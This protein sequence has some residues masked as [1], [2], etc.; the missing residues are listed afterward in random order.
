LNAL[1]AASPPVVLAAHTLTSDYE[2]LRMEALH[3]TG[4]G[5]GLTL[6]LRL[7]MNSWIEALSNRTLQAPCDST[8]RRT[9]VIPS[10]QS[11]ITLILAGMAFSQ[12]GGSYGI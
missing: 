12:L 4:R 6:F 8:D 7:G 10:S 11:E 5:L 3:G 2:E 1:E 9:S